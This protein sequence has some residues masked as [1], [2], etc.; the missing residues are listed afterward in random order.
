[1]TVL[2]DPHREES[3]CYLADLACVLLACFA[4]REDTTRSWDVKTVTEAV[5]PT[6]THT[7]VHRGSSHS[8]RSLTHENHPFSSRSARLR[9]VQQS[10]T[11]GCRRQYTDRLWISAA[12]LLTSLSLFFF[13]FLCPTRFQQLTPALVQRKQDNVGEWTGFLKR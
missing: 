5:P 12:P 11:R 7:P 2:I 9:S 1:M 4:W 8:L 13:F 10:T 3:R 6:C